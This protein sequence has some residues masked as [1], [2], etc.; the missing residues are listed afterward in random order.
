M[1]QQVETV[2]IDDLDG[3]TAETT[4]R[5]GWS[6]A[7][8]EIDLSSANAEALRE[9]MS[10]Y[11]AAGRKL[12]L[13]RRSKR[14]VADGG[15]KSTHVRAWAKQEGIAVSDRGRIPADVVAKFQAAHD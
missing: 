2:L 12:S 3:S 14:G 7:E 15:P 10:P 8:Y 4:V 11:V 6:G 1:A 5:F 13:Q 9:A